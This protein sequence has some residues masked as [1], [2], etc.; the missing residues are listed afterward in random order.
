MKSKEIKFDY[1]YL[2]WSISFKCKCGRKIEMSD[3]DYQP[4]RCS[5]CKRDYTFSSG[6][7]K[8]KKK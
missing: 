4:I 7:V 3:N 1:N 6:K 2:E 5:K 8:E